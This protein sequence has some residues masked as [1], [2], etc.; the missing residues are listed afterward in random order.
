M[1]PD[2]WRIAYS[3]EE[4]FLPQ[5]ETDGSRRVTLGY[6]TS[7]FTLPGRPYAGG[8]SYAWVK[9]FIEDYQDLHP[10]T[11]PPIPVDMVTAY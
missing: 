2:E 3:G 10:G 4:T 8:V 11:P 5:R 7:T 6:D 9:Q 1:C